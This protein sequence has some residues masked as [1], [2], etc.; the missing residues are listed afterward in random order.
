MSLKSDLS[1]WVSE[2][3]DCIGS[4]IEDYTPPYKDVENIKLQASQIKLLY[5]LAHRFD[6]YIDPV[7]Y[8]KYE[9]FSIIM[10]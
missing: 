7:I 5:D 8:D 3:I 1:E 2:Q 10:A 9:R 6:L 4:D